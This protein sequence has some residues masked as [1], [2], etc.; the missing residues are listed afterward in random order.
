M[1]IQGSAFLG[2]WT[3]IRDLDP[4]DYDRWFIH[5]HLPERV[6]I[7]GFNRGRRYRAVGE[8]QQPYFMLYDIESLS[9]LTGTEYLER[10]NNPTPATIRLM[11]HMH[12]FSRAGCRVLASKGRHVGGAMATILFEAQSDAAL[13][14]TFCEKLLRHAHILG[15]HVGQAEP[16]VSRILTTE[17]QL[18]QGDGTEG[19]VH[20]VC[21]IES[22][23]S[24]D[25]VLALPELVLEAEHHFARPATA[26]SAYSLSCL[27]P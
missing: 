13:A 25:L 8:S 7:N 6:A 4:A 15:A 27:M 11:P 19:D 18:R 3:D 9:V 10:L 22:N 14:Q 24:E 5:E 17:R 2:V 12:N 23:R 20:Q 16:S 1:A 26:C 21:M